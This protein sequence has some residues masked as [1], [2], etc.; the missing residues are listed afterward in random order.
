MLPVKLPAISV[1]GM[2]FG[3][4]YILVFVASLIVFLLLTLFLTRTTMGCRLRAVAEDLIGAQVVGINYKRVYLYAM[5]LGYLLGGISAFLL[6]FIFP[7]TPSIALDFITIA[8]VVVVTGGEGSFRGTA[9]ASLILGCAHCLLGFYA[10]TEWGT[11]AAFF[12]LLLVLLLRPQGL[13][14]VKA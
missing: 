4:S 3:S 1:G 12:I 10:T 8:I 11:I 2:T 6:S 13:F 9:V 7:I 5:L 14:G